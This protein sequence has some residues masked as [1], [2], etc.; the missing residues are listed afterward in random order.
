MNTSKLI[1]LTLALFLCINASS[2]NSPFRFGVNAGMNLSNA[3]I[4]TVETNGSS[5]R[6]GYQI[7]LTVDY[8]ISGKFNIL[9]G[10]SFIVKGSQIE[11][12]DYMSYTGGTPDFTNKFEQQYIQ[13]PLFG[14]YKINLSDDLNLMFGIGPYFAYGVGGKSKR[15]L[16]RGVYGD[17]ST[18]REFDTFGDNEEYTYFDQLK[19][20]DFGLGALVNLEYKKINLNIGYDQGL[21]NSAQS[22]Y[23]EYRN[24]SLIFSLGYKY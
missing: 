1:F 16:N 14:A 20:F 6:T 8:A 3:M 9:S 12:L 17:G 10:L 18:E 22:E 5:F 13:L 11:D 19:R 15:I 21:T 24:Y 7:G 4:G 2:Q 23:Y